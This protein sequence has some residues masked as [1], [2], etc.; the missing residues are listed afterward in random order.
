MGCAGRVSSPRCRRGPDAEPQSLSLA[1]FPFVAAGLSLNL[2]GLL[3]GA[4]VIYT[5]YKAQIPVTDDPG[6]P[7]GNIPGHVHRG[8]L[9]GLVR[10]GAA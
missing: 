5:P 4:K 8:H 10:S 9:A 1:L 7:A 2:D 6:L 3:L